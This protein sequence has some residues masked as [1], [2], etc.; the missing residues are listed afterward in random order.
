MF[1]GVFAGFVVWVVLISLA[2]IPIGHLLTFLI[3][4]G[5]LGLLL[6]D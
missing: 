1:K 4:G 5:I 2:A 6:I 3:A